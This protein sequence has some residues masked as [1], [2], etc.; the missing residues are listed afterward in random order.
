MAAA[1]RY[2]RVLLK[3]ATTYTD[4]QRPIAMMSLY[5]F[6]HN[7]LSANLAGI[8]SSVSDDLA[9]YPIE[10]LVDEDPT[11]LANFT[12]LGNEA[13]TV[14]GTIDFD[15]GVKP[16][17]QEDNKVLVDY[18]KFYFPATSITIDARIAV[19]NVMV[20]IYNSDD[21]V[22][23]NLTSRHRNGVFTAEEQTFLI[24]A[25]M[26]SKMY[27]LP[28]RERLGGGGG[29]YGIVSEDGVALP[30]RP[31]YLLDSETMQR[32]NYTT[33][34]EYGGYA[35]NGLNEN[36]E[37]VV[38]STDPSGPPYK[39][40]LIWDRVVPVNALSNTIPENAFWALRTRE[41][42]LGS[43]V[44]I[45]DWMDGFDFVDPN[46]L[47]TVDWYGL[48]SVIT[49]ITI[50]DVPNPN[51]GLRFFRSN[52]AGTAAGGNGL[53]FY[54][55]GIYGQTNNQGDTSNCREL[56]MEAI[57]RVPTVDEGRMLIWCTGT[58]D[59]DDAQV[60]NVDIGSATYGPGV[61]PLLEINQTEVNFRIPLGGRNLSI[62]RGSAPVSSGQPIHIIA[63]LKEQGSCALYINGQLVDSS[64]ISQEGRV[65]IYG[66]AYYNSQS[67][68]NIDNWDWG[69][70]TTSYGR[71]GYVR[72]Y[73]AM[74]VAG[75]ETAGNTHWVRGFGGALAW[76]AQ[77]GREFS[78]TDVER[79][80]ASYIEP[81]TT[82]VLPTLSGYA[83]QIEQDSPSWYY[84]CNELEIPN[85]VRPL[86]GHKCSASLY[87]QGV[88]LDRPA[89]V[90]GGS[91]INLSAGSFIIQGTPVWSGIFSFECFVRFDSTAGTTYL[92]LTR[93]Y[94]S[95]ATSYLSVSEGV[96]A[97]HIYEYSGQTLQ[98][99]FDYQFETGQDY[100][101]VFTYDPWVQK[102]MTLWINGVKV[103]SGFAT[104]LMRFQ[105]QIRWIGIG[106]NPSG[107]A[108]SIGDRLQGDISEVAFYSHR[109]SD[110]RI[111]AHYQSKD[112]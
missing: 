34:N 40:A 37:Y 102:E 66:K 2:W 94:N 33:T 20:E 16:D 57:V 96:P 92:F 98:Y 56:T 42:K 30:N 84:R 8:T 72:R 13:Q 68:V 24:Y 27:P 75:P 19:N 59:S 36:R 90:P 109:L 55:N 25:H 61:G 45:R 28:N 47:C 71:E 77:Y 23:W 100:H 110:E 83:G 43:S 97:F 79:F 7:H 18:I 111:Q 52:R 112:L 9:N 80:Y 64:D 85:F 26:E 12:W 58:R 35:F 4:P 49:D 32:L 22:I 106:C 108:P 88:Q 50:E 3:T 95:T 14:G 67:W 21:G 101:L 76:V 74:Y 81:T 31:V 87:E 1:A 99:R 53:L 63:T 41:P 46:A 73:T 48:G 38:I 11:T 44:A 78:Q 65:F 6:G 69:G 51:N 5:D 62:V 91:A 39:N 86:L 82:E 104:V 17:S 15:F 105:D 70:T 89:F 93:V 60:Y 10:N 29:I 103:D 54:Q 107:T